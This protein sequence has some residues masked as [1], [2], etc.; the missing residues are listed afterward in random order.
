PPPDLT[1]RGWDCSNSL[2]FC[3][4]IVYPNEDVLGW[5]CRT[6]LPCCYTDLDD[7]DDD[8]ICEA[9]QPGGGCSEFSASANRP[10]VDWC[11]GQSR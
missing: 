2:G 11:P 8:C 5:Q 6:K 3:V 7:D 1:G 9:A 4:C 10:R